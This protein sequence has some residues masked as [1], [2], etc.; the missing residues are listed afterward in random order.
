MRQTRL[1]PGASWRAM[2]LP[3][4]RGQ[5][6]TRPGE[7]PDAVKCVTNSEPP[8]N[9]RASPLKKPPPVLVSIVMPS[10]IQA[11]WCVWLKD[12]LARLQEHLQRL[13]RRAHDLMLHRCPPVSK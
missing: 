3:G 13:K 12:H 10:D 1:S 6:A 11:I 7:G 2:R 4:K 9:E 5:K 8:E